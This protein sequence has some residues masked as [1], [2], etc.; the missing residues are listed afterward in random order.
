MLMAAGSFTSCDDQLDIEPRDRITD[1]DYFKTEDDL[2][3]FSNP[4]Y[5][6]IL[7]KKGYDSQN[8]LMVSQ[9][10]SNELRGGNFRPIPKTSGGGG[11]SW[12]D[13]RRINTLLENIHNCSD[14]AAVVKYTAISRFFRAYFYY[15]KVVRFGD[16][17]WY[18]QQIGSADTDLL[19]KARD[20]R[21]FV[22]TKMLEDIDYAINNLPDHKAQTNVPYRAT[23]WAALAL[24][25]RF[26]LFEGTYRKYHG[27]NLDGHD[28]NFYLSEAASA[29]KELIQDG[30][31]KIWK[32]GKPESDYR[33]LFIA[34]DAN[35]DEYILAIRYDKVT[36][37]CH[38][39]YGFSFTPSRGMPGYTRKFVNMYLMKDGSRFTDKPGWQEM[40]YAE[41]IVDR[42]P[43]LTQSIRTPGF[44]LNKK[45]HNPNPSESVTGYNPIKFVPDGITRNDDCINDLPVF[46]IAEVM[47]IYA[48]ARAEL[49]ELTQ[50]DLNI[51]VNKIR[52]RVGMPNLDMATA[53]ANPDYYLASAEYGYPNVTGANKGVI[54]EI[55]RERAIELSQEGGRWEDIRRWKA[56]KCYDQAI[57]GMYFPGA[58]NYDLDGDG[59]P[60][61]VLYTADQA[62]PDV[63]D[64]QVYQIGSE[65]KLTDGTKGYINYH[66]NVERGPFNEDRDYLYPI[67]SYDIDLCKAA[68]HPIAQNP[69]WK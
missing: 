36:S 15:D 46:R 35:S 53:N 26:C 14:E 65:I 63:A 24:K 42:D 54:L 50:E 29:A 47:L 45:V 56:G 16:V 51:T 18:E 31:Y 39:A 1:K 32:S 52:E 9:D 64:A 55:R 13:L 21:E 37:T 30:P 66:G 57:T 58:G 11:W 48:E 25:A 7:P 23:K 38:D 43:R 68:G 59:K 10:L 19:Y 44:T 40:T 61:I 49:G 8:D 28:A 27:I 22:M 62:K 5:N 69:G 3:L 4:F 12:T 20:S 17:P 60:E 6:N 41:E 34:S 2:M 33:D 67:P